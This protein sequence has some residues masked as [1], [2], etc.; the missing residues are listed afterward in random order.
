MVTSLD[1]VQLQVCYELLQQ[2]YSYLQVADEEINKA[3]LSADSIEEV[4]LEEIT[5]RLAYTSLMQSLRSEVENEESYN[6]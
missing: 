6:R 5:T 1:L 4:V 2:K 3:I